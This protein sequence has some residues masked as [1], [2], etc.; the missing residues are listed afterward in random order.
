MAIVRGWKV[1]AIIVLGCLLSACAPGIKPGEASIPDGAVVTHRAVL[2]GESNHDTI[3]TISLYQSTQPPVVVFEPNFRL[4]PVPGTGVALGRDGYRPDTVLG[5]LL[6]AYGRQVYAVPAHLEIK[7]YNE[8][9][10]W[11]PKENR[12]LGLGRLTL[13]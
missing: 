1:F 6:R 9:W 4:T 2:I 11:N 5:A 10:L 13:L 8:V 12:P 7:A 3:G